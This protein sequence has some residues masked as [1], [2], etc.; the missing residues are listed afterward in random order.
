[1]LAG[2]D[3]LRNINEVSMPCSSFAIEAR[4]ADCSG[5][6]VPDACTRHYSRHNMMT[7]GDYPESEAVSPDWLGLELAD[8]RDLLVLDSRS[9][10]DFNKSHIQN[11]IHVTIPSL[12]QKRLKKGN[13]SVD[14]VIK[15]HRFSTRWRTD[16]IILYDE[17]TVDV[18]ESPNGLITL[19]YQRLSEDGCK[20]HYLQGKLVR[21]RCLG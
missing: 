21:V 2:S 20:V 3:V 11:A 1:M 18:K 19:L 16:T 17:D 6:V 12:M 8:E 7:V 10:N 13:L 15:C 14:S 5:P 4:I 9:A